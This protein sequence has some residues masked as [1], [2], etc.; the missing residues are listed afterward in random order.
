MEPQFPTDLDSYCQHFKIN[1][2]DLVLNC[3]FCKFPL[4]TVDLASFHNKKLSII[5]RNYKPF[6]CCCKCLRLT[7]KFE[8]ENYFVCTVKSHLLT[9]LI[10]KELSEINIR[11][12]ECYAFLD[13]LEKLSHLYND[14]DFAFIRGH[15]RG[16]CRNCMQP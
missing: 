9:G 13:Y 8:K 6:V 10:K 3:I 14:L 11:C 2:F 1:F 7:A 5:W 15:W 12:Q 16:T 4:S